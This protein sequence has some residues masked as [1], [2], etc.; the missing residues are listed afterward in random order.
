MQLR[1]STSHESTRLSSGGG[2]AG[3]VG[4]AP[5]GFG[6]TNAMAENDRIVLDV[7]TE[8]DEEQGA[9]R[10]VTEDDDL[11]TAEQ[12]GDVGGDSP[13]T[14]LIT[15]DDDIVTAEQAGVGTRSNLGS[16]VL[17]YPSPRDHEREAEQRTQQ[18]HDHPQEVNC[19]GIN[20][21]IQYGGSSSSSGPRAPR[22]SSRTTG[23]GP[24]NKNTSMSCRSPRFLE[25]RHR[26]EMPLAS[27]TGMFGALA[28]GFESLVVG[29]ESQGQ[30]S[31][32]DNADEDRRTKSA[33]N[34]G[35]KHKEA[36]SGEYPKKYREGGRNKTGTGTRGK[37]TTHTS[38]SPVPEQIDQPVHQAVCFKI[39]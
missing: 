21:L 37:V 34:K 3:G 6:I 39:S 35:D 11:V 20:P 19:H 29:E 24:R 4:G 31:V 9:T 18:E 30:E 10:P 12:A 22:G 23:E 14:R 1:N 26:M 25:G 5:F 33:V 32:D 7:V 15:E 38:T 36:S 13:A 8:K 17:R 2:V 16:P 27:P 28:A